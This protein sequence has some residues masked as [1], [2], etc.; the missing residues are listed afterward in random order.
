MKGSFLL[1][2]HSHASAKPDKMCDLRIF[3]VQHQRSYRSRDFDSLARV[4][5]GEAS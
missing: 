5:V 1:A 2:A 4:M 3:D